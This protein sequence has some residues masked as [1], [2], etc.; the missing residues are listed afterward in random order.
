MWSRSRW[1][2]QNILSERGPISLCQANITF[3]ARRNR[4]IRHGLEIEQALKWNFMFFAT[5]KAQTRPNLTWRRIWKGRRNNYPT[6]QLPITKRIAR[7]AWIC[8]FISLGSLAFK[9]KTISKIP[10]L[11][12][13]TCLA[14]F[15]FYSSVQRCTTGM[16]GLQRDNAAINPPIGRGGNQ[17]CKRS[18]IHRHFMR[19][20]LWILLSFTDELR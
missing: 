2:R 13:G 11:V 9:Q 20:Y 16:N 7:L 19:S 6:T 12:W 15:G 4:R 18:V 3:E 8:G 10:R 14:V 5:L 1:A 17:N